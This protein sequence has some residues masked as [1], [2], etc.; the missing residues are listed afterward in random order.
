MLLFWRDVH[1]LRFEAP[2]KSSCNVD[3]N[4]FGVFLLFRL[5][6]CPFV[7][8]VDFNLSSTS[9]ALPPQVCHNL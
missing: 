1:R 2:L 8:R 6:I 7:R 4:L 3:L 5:V 9:L